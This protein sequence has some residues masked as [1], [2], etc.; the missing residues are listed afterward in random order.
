LSI[1]SWVS[2]KD[3]LNRLGKKRGGWKRFGVQPSHVGPD[4]VVRAGQRKPARSC[5][6]LL[7]RADEGIH[8]YVLVAIY[9]VFLSTSA[10]FLDPKPT[11]LQIAC[12]IQ[13]LRPMSGT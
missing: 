1:D 5:R 2:T 10:E 6:A 11:Q 13:A 12:S 3:T 9:A 7:R 8:P 4:A